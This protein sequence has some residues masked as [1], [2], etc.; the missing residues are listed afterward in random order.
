MTQSMCPIPALPLYFS[1]ILH[2]TQ[3]HTQDLMMSYVMLEGVGHFITSVLGQTESAPNMLC[4]W[5]P[6][7][8]YIEDLVFNQF[9]QKGEPRGCKRAA[10]ICVWFVSQIIIEN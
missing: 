1:L 6:G 5:Q 4:A 3:A 7:A 9:V 2:I 10:F 8:I